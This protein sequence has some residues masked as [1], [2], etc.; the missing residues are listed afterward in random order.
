MRARR[1]LPDGVFEETGNRSEEMEGMVN[2]ARP[3]LDNA[4]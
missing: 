2:Y 4:R 1:I 3:F